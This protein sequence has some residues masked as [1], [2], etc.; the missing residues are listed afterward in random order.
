MGSV[1]PQ[2]KPLPTPF[3]NCLINKE[4]Q[5]DVICKQF[6]CAHITRDAEKTVQDQLSFD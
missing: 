4:E 1:L 6:A 5:L 2:N 3:P